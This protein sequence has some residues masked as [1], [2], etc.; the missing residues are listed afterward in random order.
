MRTISTLSPTGQVLLVWQRNIRKRDLDLPGIGRERPVIGN[1]QEL[2]ELT[3]SLVP[4]NNGKPCIHSAVQRA[5]D[6]KPQTAWNT[7]RLPDGIQRCTGMHY[8]AGRVKQGLIRV[9]FLPARPTWSA[10]TGGAARIPREFVTLRVR[11]ARAAKAVDTKV[12]ALL[13]HRR[14]ATPVRYS[15]WTKPGHEPA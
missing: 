8:R 6:G 4:P 1:L 10:V 12:V 7:R 5:F 14:L 9:W 13:Q 15:R 2:V 3:R 11:R